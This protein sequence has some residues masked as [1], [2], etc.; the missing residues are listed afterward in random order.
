[1]GEG[2]YDMEQMREKDKE[3]EEQRGKSSSTA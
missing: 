2:K 3:H 1:M